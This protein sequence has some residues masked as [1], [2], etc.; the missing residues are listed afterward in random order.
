MQQDPIIEKLNNIESLILDRS[1]SPF[2]FVEACRYLGLRPSY[3]YKLTALKKIP[4]YKPSGKKIFFYKNELDEW[5]KGRY[6]LKTQN[7]Y[8]KETNRGNK[9]GK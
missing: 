9:Y 2:T 1:E 5:I 3:L 4:C 7:K 6:G 8:K